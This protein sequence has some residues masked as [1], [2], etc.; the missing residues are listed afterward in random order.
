MTHLG[1]FTSTPRYSQP[2]AGFFVEGEPKP[3]QDSKE[4]K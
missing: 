3:Q 1:S 2:V 4:S